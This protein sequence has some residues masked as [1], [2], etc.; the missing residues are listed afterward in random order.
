MINLSQ[1]AMLGLAASLN[2]SIQAHKVAFAPSVDNA[3]RIEKLWLVTFV[4][5]SGQEVVAQAKAATGQYVPLIAADEGRLESIIEAGR[6]LAKANSNKFRIIE[7]TG[8]SDLGDI[9]P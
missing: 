8:R 4:D 3:Q 6:G 9:S 2:W 5:N 7:F 1:V